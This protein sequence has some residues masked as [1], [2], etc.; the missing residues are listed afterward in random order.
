MIDKTVIDK[1]RRSM[2]LTK[3]VA[4]L[5]TAVSGR[6]ISILSRDSLT[7]SFH[8]VFVGQRPGLAV[9][10]YLDRTDPVIGRLLAGEERVQ[11]E[12]EY[13]DRAEANGVST[14]S[15]TIFPLVVSGYI[16]HVLMIK[17]RNLSEHDDRLVSAYCKQA[18]L[19]LETIAMQV[20]LD[21]KIERLATFASHV[22]DLCLEQ[23]HRSLLQTV[24]DRSTDLLLAEQGSIMLIEK[25]T[26]LLLLEASKGTS[27][28]HDAQVRIARGVGIA[29]RVAELGE[30]ILVADIERDP[31]V[32]RKNR[33]QYKSHSF[34]SVP[35]KLGRRVV[36]VMNFNDKQTGELFD[37]VDLRFAQTCASHAAVVLD[38]R[39]I[40]EETVKLARQSSV[41][42]LTGLLNRG[43][44]LS[45]IKEEVARAERY[46]KV[47]SIAMLDIDGFKG[48][49]DQLGHRAGDRVL[50]RTAQIMSAAVRSM[51]IIGRYGGDEFVIVLPETDA[52]FAAQIAERIRSGVARTDIE[53]KIDHEILDRVTVSIGIATFPAH[54]TKLEVLIDH[55]DEALYRAKEGGRDRV[56]VY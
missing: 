15:E 20:N 53:H 7:G 39:Q 47:L 1:E 36:G 46:N 50:Q 3:L 34:V 22:D 6:A 49:N 43:R 16:D 52:Y 14:V 48:I 13:E 54:G 51:D 31:R 4:D 11:R 5:N 21:R 25:E 23:S 18:A 42:D 32:G 26:D 10:D 19:A 17:G 12:R 9:M 28:D 44:I 56:E 55:A 37:D 33:Q 29:G 27:R 30:P 8:G 45:R 2:V 35:L 38:R 41:D 24:L 40:Y